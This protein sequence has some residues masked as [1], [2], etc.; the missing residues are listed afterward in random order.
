LDPALAPAHGEAARAVTLLRI[1]HR[2]SAA[3]FA[4]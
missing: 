1:R 4:S 2:Q 3:D